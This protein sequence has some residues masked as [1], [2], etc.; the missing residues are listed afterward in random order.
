LLGT[1]RTLADRERRT[2]AQDMTMKNKTGFM[3]I[4][5]DAYVV[6]HARSNPDDKP[7]QV[8][9]WLRRALRDHKA[10]V[11]CRCGN[12][13]WVIGSAIAGNACFTCITAKPGPIPISRSTKPWN[14]GGPTAPW[15]AQGVSQ[16][17]SR[18]R[19]TARPCL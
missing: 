12:P 9:A 13:I 18:T 15:R 11:K 8:R 14:E 5:I 1:A 3:P 6:R 16:C 17:C 7:A 4:S 10:G 19:G 2:F